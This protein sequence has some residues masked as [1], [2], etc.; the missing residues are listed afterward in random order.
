MIYLKILGSDRS[1]TIY[2][3]LE[4]ITYIA[5]FGESGN[6]TLFVFNNTD[7]LPFDIPF[8]VISHELHQIQLVSKKLYI[9]E[10][11]R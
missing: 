6:S 5:P 10:I 8:S 11:V 4:N 3:N 7:E 9:K 2:I 1:K